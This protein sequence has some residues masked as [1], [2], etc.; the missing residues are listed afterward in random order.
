[1]VTVN[2]TAYYKLPQTTSSDA[3]GNYHFDA[4]QDDSYDVT[5]KTASGL[6]S[7]K[8]A[9]VS[10]RGVTTLDLFSGNDC[11]TVW[12]TSLSALAVM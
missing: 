9:V 8:A 6:S 7:E 5:A 2:T 1:L 4:L 12:T 11:G 10:F 3:D